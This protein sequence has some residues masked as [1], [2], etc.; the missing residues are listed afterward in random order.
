MIGRMGFYTSIHT[1][2]HIHTHAY[3]TTQG[4]YCS[5]EREREIAWLKNKGLGIRRSRV[6][7]SIPGRQ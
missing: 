1:H 4:S 2:T 6:S 3:A 5:I 7:L